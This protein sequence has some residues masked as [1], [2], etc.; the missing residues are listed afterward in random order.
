M[1]NYVYKNPPDNSVG[2]DKKQDKITKG[3]EVPYRSKAQKAYLQIHYPELAKEFAE[4]TKKNADLP[5]HVKK[6]ILP[7]KEYKN[8]LQSYGLSSLKNNN[9][10]VTS[11]QEAR[12]LASQRSGQSY[13]QQ[14][15]KFKNSDRFGMRNKDG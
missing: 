10:A 15:R 2:M 6:D 14:I 7:T 8:T 12:Q 5:N 13:N 11:P 3:V 1:P 4:H 9:G